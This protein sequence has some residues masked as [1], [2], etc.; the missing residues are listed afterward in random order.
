MLP[1]H[2]NISNDF[3][4]KGTS[5]AEDWFLTSEKGA[6]TFFLKSEEKCQLFTEVW[7]SLLSSSV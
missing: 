1:S 7:G 3:L 5:P 6:L 4:E 2:S